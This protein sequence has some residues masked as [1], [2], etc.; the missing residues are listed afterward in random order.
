[1][2]TVTLDVSA[3][4]ST[5]LGDQAAQA[6]ADLMPLLSCGEEAAANTFA[7]LAAQPAFDRLAS[8]ASPSSPS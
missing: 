5:R 2:A 1:M 6:L 8:T 4:A 3:P 7:R